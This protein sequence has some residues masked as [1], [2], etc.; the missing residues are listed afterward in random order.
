MYLPNKLHDPVISNL[1][2]LA[3]LK[4]YL[5]LGLELDLVVEL[6]SEI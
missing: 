4:S 6:K 1:I 3:K 5:E 2:F